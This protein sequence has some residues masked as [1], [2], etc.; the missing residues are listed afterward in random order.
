MSDSTDIGVFGPL[1]FPLL[2]GKYISNHKI[3]KNMRFMRGNLEEKI[4]QR[5]TRKR[6]KD[7]DLLLVLYATHETYTGRRFTQV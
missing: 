6:T 5:T 2:S 3:H 7:I 1:A 4:V